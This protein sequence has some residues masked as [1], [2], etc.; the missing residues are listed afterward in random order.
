M[1][2]MPLAVKNQRLLFYFWSSTSILAVLEG[3]LNEKGRFTSP[4]SGSNPL[5]NLVDSAVGMLE[6]PHTGGD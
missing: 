6:A 5:R 3:A 4:W 2:P 1:P